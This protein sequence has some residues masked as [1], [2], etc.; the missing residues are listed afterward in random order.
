[1]TGKREMLVQCP[2]CTTKVQITIYKS[3][4]VS[5]D[6]GAKESFL[7]G[8]I[9]LFRCTGCSFEAFFPAPFTYHDRENKIVAQCYPYTFIEEDRFFSRFT[10]DG[11]MTGPPENAPGLSDI[12]YGSDIHIVFSMEELAR[13]VAFR[14]RLREV[15]EKEK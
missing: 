13:Y 4:D 3:L 10:A 14:D 1:M 15:K 9:N 5:E 12:D 7:N 2:E 8:A 11:K 6:P